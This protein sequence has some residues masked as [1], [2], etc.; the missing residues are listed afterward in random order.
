MSASCS[1]LTIL[2]TYDE[3]KSLT[4]S[5]PRRLHHPLRG[6]AD[7][8]RNASPPPRAG[9]GSEAQGRSCRSLEVGKKLRSKL[10]NL[11]KEILKLNKS[12]GRQPACSVLDQNVPKYFTNVLLFTTKRLSLGVLGLCND[13]H[14]SRSTPASAEWGTARPWW[15]PWWAAT[16]TSS[17]PGASTT[18][19]PPSR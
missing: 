12:V 16:T 6:D 14:M 15:P 7:R 10:Q 3:R 9:P 11:S 5:T 1:P 2:I 8:G 19:G 4:N 18:S 13:L 17:S